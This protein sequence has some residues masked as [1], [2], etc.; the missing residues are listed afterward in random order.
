VHG[1]VTCHGG[2][3]EVTSEPGVGTRFDVLLPIAPAELL[4]AS[5]NRPIALPAA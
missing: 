3:I 4:E 1:I 2:R 5:P